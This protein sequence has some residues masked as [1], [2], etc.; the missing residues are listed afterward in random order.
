MLSR[1][2]G[3]DVGAGCVLKRRKHP[4]GQVLAHRKP[5]RANLQHLRADAGELEHFLERDLPE[6]ARARHDAR[7][8]RVDP[9]D[10]GVDVAAVGLDAGSNCDGR[11]VRAAAAQGGHAAVG[12]DALEAGDHCDGSGRQRL[13]E[14]R[15]FDGLDPGIAVDARGAD[16][17]PAHEAARLEAH[18]LEGH[19]EQPGR[20]LLATG[21]NHVIF[22]RVVERGGLAAQL[23]EA[24][25]LAG[26]G[27]DDDEHLVAALR[28]APDTLGDASDAL[29]PRHR[30]AAEFHDDARHCL[31]LGSRVADC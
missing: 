22:L 29:D 27:G 11:G 19:G 16:Q 10:V 20:H 24:V 1:K 26:H 3:D 17:L 21:N 7:V 18:V 8:G 4:Q 14:K 6:L 25:G 15:A 12:R 23:D 31:L 2:L 13:V 5:D 28:L 30:R 9:L